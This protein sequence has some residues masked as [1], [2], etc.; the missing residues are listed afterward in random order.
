M[1]ARTESEVIEGG[2][3]RCDFAV[4]LPIGEPDTAIDDG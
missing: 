3:Q 4:P 2:D 1:I